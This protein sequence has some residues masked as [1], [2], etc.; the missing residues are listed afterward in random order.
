MPDYTK[1]VIYKLINYDCQDLVYVGSTTNFT[2]RK[3]QHKQ[4]TNENVNRKL[5]NTIREKG[6]WESWNM[7]KICDFPCNTSA[8]ARQEEDR[9]MI[10]LKS[11][12]NS[13]RA[14]MSDEDKKERNKKYREANKEKIQEA[15]KERY[16]KTK[17]EKLTTQP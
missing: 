5:Y 4:K 6:G 11:N 8:E 3:A 16:R 17:K 10:L 15:K 13:Y 1:T 7:I 14:Y 12:L 2:K 9:H